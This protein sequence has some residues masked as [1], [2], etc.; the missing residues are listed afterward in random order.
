MTRALDLTREF[1]LAARA[2]SCLAARLDFTR[3]GDVAPEGVN[4]LV[5]KALAFGAVSLTATPAPA[6][7]TVSAFAPVTVIAASAATPAV[8]SVSTAIPAISPVCATPAS[9][10]NIV[11]FNIAH[12]SHSLWITKMRNRRFRLHRPKIQTRHD[13]RGG[14]QAESSH[15]RPVQYENASCR[16]HPPNRVFA[17]DLRRRP[18]GLSSNAACKSRQGCPMPRR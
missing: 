6:K 16:F 17:G 18:A 11:A 13:A 15:W 10:S 12:V 14:H 3:L 4:I 2:V 8:I 9:F 5:V 7:I 1:A